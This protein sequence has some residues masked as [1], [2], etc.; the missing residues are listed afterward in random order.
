[1][2]LLEIHEPG[3]TPLPHA[4]EAG[5]AVGIDLGTTNSVVAIA[6]AAKPVGEW[7]HTRIVVNR[8]HVELSLNGTKTAEYVMWTPE[9]EKLVASGKWRDYPDYGRAR[10]GRI[11][12]QDHG[13]KVWFR[14]IKV[15]VKLITQVRIPFDTRG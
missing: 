11:G 7:N 12:L 6:R 14:N 1:M 15:R 3:Q 2:T 5:H 10:K 13:N 4:D 8:G 9:W